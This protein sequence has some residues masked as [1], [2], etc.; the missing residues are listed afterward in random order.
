MSSF[1][2][3][4]WRGSSL[5]LCKVLSYWLDKKLLSDAIW[6]I[7]SQVYADIAGSDPERMAPPRVAEYVENIFKDTCVKVWD[8]PDGWKDMN[9]HTCICNIFCNA[10]K[11]KWNVLCIETNSDLASNKWEVSWW[12]D[13]LKNVFPLSNRCLVWIMHNVRLVSAEMKKGKVFCRVM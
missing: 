13:S 12:V 4:Q 10:A 11:W 1:S 7:F 5:N 8:D 6:C 9:V 3:K 2:W